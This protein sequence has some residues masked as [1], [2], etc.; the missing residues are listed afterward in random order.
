M[1]R[2]PTITARQLIR[3][4]RKLGFTETR[5]RGSHHRFVHADGRKTTVP[6]HKGRDIPIG[7]LRQIVTIDCEMDLDSFMRML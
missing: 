2:N 5:S 1:S 3:V 7:L 6:I 4:L